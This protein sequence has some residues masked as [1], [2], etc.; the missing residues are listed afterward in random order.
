VFDG[1]FG[2]VDH[3]VPSF[4]FPDTGATQYAVV[5]VVVCPHAD[6]PTTPPTTTTPARRTLPEAKRLRDDDPFMRF[7]LGEVNDSRGNP[8]E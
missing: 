8:L 6:T 5:V 1:K 7:P 3:F 4:Q 2:A